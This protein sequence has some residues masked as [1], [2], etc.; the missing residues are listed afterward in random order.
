[1]RDPI[2][3]RPVTQAD[4][5]F[6]SSLDGHLSPGGF[7]RKVRDRMG[8]VL[9]LSGDPAGILRFSLFWDEIPFCDLIRI[10][11]DARGKGCGRALMAHWEKDM[12]A[13]GFDLALT[14]TQADEEAQHFY[15]ALGYRDCGAFTL[16]FPGHEQPTEIILGKHL[17]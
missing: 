2:S 10:R 3:V 13:R 14:S 8:Y 15:R 5:A 12:A 6:W 1:M 16:P 4:R 7:D 9:F 11:E 17:A